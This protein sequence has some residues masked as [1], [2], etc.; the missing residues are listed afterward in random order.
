MKQIK[1][2][3]QLAIDNGYYAEH[4]FKE[5]KIVKDVKFVYDE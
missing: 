2:Y 5:L 3:L 4:T 1:D